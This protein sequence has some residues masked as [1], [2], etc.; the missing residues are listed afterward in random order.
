MQDSQLAKALQLI[1]LNYTKCEEFKREIDFLSSGGNSLSM[2]RMLG[3]ICKEFGIRFSF[4]EF[5]ERPTYDVLE[6]LVLTAVGSR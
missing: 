3:A 5:Q 2:V 4:N 1:W 6:K